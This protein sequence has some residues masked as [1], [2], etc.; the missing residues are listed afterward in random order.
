[1]KT[2]DRYVITAFLKNYCISF[3]VLVGMFVVLDMVFKFDDIVEVQSRLGPASPESTFV[4]IKAII[5]FYFYKTFLFFLYLGP[6]I[7]GVAASFTLLRLTRNNELTAIMAAGVPLLRVA[8][9]IILIAVVLSGLGAVDQ[10][11]VI[12][13]IIP[14]LM[15]KHSQIVGGNPSIRN[16]PP[17]RDS[18]NRIFMAS[19]YYSPTETTPAAMDF[20]D[21]VGR[22]ENMRP[23]NHLYADRAIWDAKKQQWELTNGFLVE[24]LLPESR[25][26]E[27]RP[28]TTLKTSITPDEIALFRSG[29]YVDLLSTARI[30]Q[31]LA[32]TETYGSIDLLRVM[33]SRYAQLLLNIILLLLAIPS[34]LTRDT[35]RLRMATAQALALTGLC[36]GTVFLSHNLAGQLPPNPAWTN[37]WPALMAWMPVFIFGPLS[38]WLL[39]RVKT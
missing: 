24:G 29:D 14:E 35:S 30:R 38:V 2:L 23:L 13:N 37:T 18:E 3:L 27:P 33:H 6:V 5:S 25:P 34:V 16:V 32:R 15:T 4:L 36:L 10:E 12:P 11:L 8:A 20:L 26:T 39:D 19:R 1:M 28:V 21:V 22:D 17:M 9:P 31:L 7:P